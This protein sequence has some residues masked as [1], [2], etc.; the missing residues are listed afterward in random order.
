MTASLAHLL[1]TIDCFTFL[2]PNSSLLIIDPFGLLQ[3][4]H[5]RILIV[6]LPYSYSPSCSPHPKL[7]SLVHPNSSNSQ[8]VN[9]NTFL[10]Q[11]TLNLLSYA[12]K[13]VEWGRTTRSR[14]QIP[15]SIKNNTRWFL[16]IRGKPLW[17]IAYKYLVELV[18]VLTSW[19]AYHCHPKKLF[20]FHFLFIGKLN[21]CL[22]YIGTMT[23]VISL[24]PALSILNPPHK[25]IIFLDHISYF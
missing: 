7:E 15:T 10:W 11:I 16:P 22:S 19:L 25:K 18:E 24:L 1:C 12:L 3:L 21:Y 2:R 9:L 6:V 23:S 13:F 14:V 4:F 5:R 20:V 8:H 17:V